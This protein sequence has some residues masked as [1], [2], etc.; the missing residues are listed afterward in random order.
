MATAEYQEFYKLQ[1][2]TE[3]ERQ[4]VQSHTQDWLHGPG[5]IHSVIQ[6]SVFRSSSK[7]GWIN[8]NSGEINFSPHIS[9]A[10]VAQRPTT[11]S[12]SVESRQSDHFVSKHAGDFKKDHDASPFSGLY[13]VPSFST[14]APEGPLPAGMQQYCYQ[15]HFELGEVTHMFGGLRVDPSAN[16]RLL[17]IPR[18]T[19]LSRIS[20]HLSGDLPPFVNKEVLMSP[21]MYPNPS[22]ILFN[23][24]RGTVQEYGREG[25]GDVFPGH[26]LQATGTQVSP[27][28][29]FW[30][31]GF[32][33]KVVSVS[34]NEDVD[35]WIVEKKI[36]VNDHGYIM[37]GRTLRFTRVDIRSKSALRYVGR[38]GSALVS[39]SFEEHPSQVGSPHSR[40]ISSPVWP[41][42]EMEEL[43][44]EKDRESDREKSRKSDK[45]AKNG[46]GEKPGK[47]DK[48]DTTDRTEKID[49]SDRTIKIDKTIKFDT[50]VKTDSIDSIETPK[51]DKSERTEKPPSPQRS[52]KSDKDDKTEKNEK[53]DRIDNGKAAKD[54]TSKP[55]D[56][57][58]P[59]P[60]RQEKDSPARPRVSPDQRRP[61][62]KSSP[63]LSASK[64]TSM[65]HKSTRIFHRDRS[66][67]GKQMPS[68]SPI[69]SSYS[70]QVKHNRTVPGQSPLSRPGSPQMSRKS[71]VVP[72]SRT[73]TGSSD[74]TGS[75]K[76]DSDSASSMSSV[77]ALAIPA[78]RRLRQSQK[79]Q[80]EKN[81]VF[82]E[83]TFIDREM[84][85]TTPVKPDVVSITVYQFGGF[86]YAEDEDGRPHFTSTNELLKIELLLNG[87]NFHSEAL[88]LEISSG[89]NDLWP[90]P[91]GFFA[92][93]LLDAY[94]PSET[95]DIVADR[96]SDDSA[97]ASTSES[98][99][100]LSDILA[101]KSDI[102]M[103]K[104][105]DPWGA[106]P[107]A[108]IVSEKSAP[109]STQSLGGESFF[110]NKCLMVHGGVNDQHEVF[111][112][113][114]MYSF[115][116]GKWD[117]VSTYVF[118]YYNIPKQPY[119]D[120][121][122]EDL[123]LENQVKAPELVEADFRSCHHRAH[124]YSEDGTDYVFFLGGFQNDYL[125]HFDKTP[126]TS[127]KFDVSR[128]S[129]FSFSSTNSNLLRIPVLNVRSQRWK[130]SRFFYD[131]S[132]CVTPQAMEILMGNDFMR[133]TR[134]SFHGGAFSL[135]GKQITICHGIV[136]FVPEK[137]EDFGKISKHLNATTVLLGGH[138]HLTFPN[139]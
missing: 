46:K 115:V 60:V 121:K 71:P 94:S 17:G 16:L 26:L 88:V 2:Q 102:W 38:L 35:R 1:K 113:L 76:G 56:K 82:G 95:C 53:S 20:V 28:E 118:D 124:I 43:E 73:N 103:E 90:S 57:E 52:E 54:S 99:D 93:I 119:E 4:F 63:P 138:T 30:C 9:M 36:V 91:R 59:K 11:R 6:Y 34:H 122:T 92:S 50:T 21:M 80:A 69:Q 137:K 48:I 39:N 116:T 13:H 96:Y 45:V 15:A 127:N 131:L 136:E 42:D 47:V 78:P 72:P 84:G 86:K 133:N 139:M 112:E 97:S 27:H 3:R 44:I 104:S 125:R 101:E 49:K 41:G 110:E 65:L 5:N 33:A 105:S 130:F 7:N 22:F 75:D 68:P 117:T 58:K 79:E 128:I 120:E 87:N 108:D 37:D 114:Y 14:A 134:T 29:V 64:M 89:A 107:A 19:D 40:G 83:R 109:L 77:P 67:S 10:P 74:R 126:Y 111:S 61:D 123:Q 129:K 8:G 51:V 66:M 18:S 55:D 25:F 62:T 81:Q 100:R 98:G 32:E 70:N 85:D 31:G 23:P 24:T 135:V 132:E 106:K 12:S